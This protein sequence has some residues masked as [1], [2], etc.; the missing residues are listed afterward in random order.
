APAPEGDRGWRRWLGGPAPAGRRGR[1]QCS[2]SPTA[3]AR[4]LTA[5]STQLLTSSSSPAS[6]SGAL[7]G[8]DRHAV[9]V[10]VQRASPRGAA[11]SDAEGMTVRAGPATEKVT[12]RAA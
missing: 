3:R 5:P 6:T 9:T 7:E 12:G 2:D 1:I 11:R 8:N 10:L 4:A